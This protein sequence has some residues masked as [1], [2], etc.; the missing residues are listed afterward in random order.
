MNSLIRYDIELFFKINGQWHN[1]FLDWLL[2]ALRNQYFWSPLYLFTVVFVILNFKKK[3]LMWLAFFLINFALTDFISSSLIKP[4]VGRLR[5]CADPHL[6]HGVRKVVGCGGPY[7]FTSSHA[8]NHF[9]MAMFAFITLFF[10]PKHWRWLL[11]LWAFAISYAQIYVG[12]H[13]PLDIFCGSLL[14]CIIGF[15]TAWVFNKK[16]GLPGLA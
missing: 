16:I 3:G 2:P 15:G 11:F 5:P 8:T 10:I 7:S 6:A 4:W 9:G 1:S 12:V 13:F 14:G